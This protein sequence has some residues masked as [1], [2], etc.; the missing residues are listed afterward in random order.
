[1]ANDYNTQL[2]NLTCNAEKFCPH[3]VAER[4]ISA[5]RGKDQI[6]KIKVVNLLRVALKIRSKDANALFQEMYTGS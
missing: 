4:L 1:M 6:W 5:F 2:F 3:V